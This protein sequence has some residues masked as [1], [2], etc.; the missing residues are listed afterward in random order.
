M[1]PLELELELETYKR[2]VPEL[3]DDQGKFALIRGENLAGIYDTYE[4]A[5]NAGDDKFGF[6]SFLIK[7]IETVEKPGCITGFVASAS[8]PS[9]FRHHQSRDCSGDR[10]LTAAAR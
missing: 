9:P 10:S 4:D 8:P 6:V 5:L 1:A 3:R 2:K 7:Q